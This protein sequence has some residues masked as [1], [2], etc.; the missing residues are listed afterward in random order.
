MPATPKEGKKNSAEISRVIRMN[1]YRVVTAT[2][3]LSD[4]RTR[5]IRLV[6]C[7]KL[8]ASRGKVA[9]LPGA[10]ENVVHDVRPHVFFISAMSDKREKI[11]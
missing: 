10:D 7:G 1:I 5:E 9:E 11:N 3:A 8:D 6:K 2:C 4:F